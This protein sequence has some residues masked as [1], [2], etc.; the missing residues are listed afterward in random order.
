MAATLRS[1][2]GVGRNLVRRSA[3]GFSV[4]EVLVTGTLIA[5]L[6]AAAGAPIVVYMRRA[7]GYAASRDIAGQIRSAR[8]TA[9]TS[10]KTMRVRFSCPGPLQYRVLEFTNNPA[11]D[12]AVDRCT[13]PYPD[14]NPAVLPNNDGPPMWLPQGVTFSATQDLSISTTGVV[15]PLTGASPAVLVVSDGTNTRQI[16]VSTAGRVRTP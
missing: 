7:R 8:L 4:L 10:N 2:E 6:T 3:A 14:P 13:Y 15:T 9:V 16:I 5:V 1:I 12:N 11:I